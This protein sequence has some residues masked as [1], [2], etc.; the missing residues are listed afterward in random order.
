MNARTAPRPAGVTQIALAAGFGIGAVVTARHLDAHDE[1]PMTPFGFR[2]FSGPFESAGKDG[3]LILLAGMAAVSAVDA[4]AG[5]QLLRGRRSGFD[6]GFL[7]ALPSYALSIGFF[8]PIMLVGVPLR[9]VLSV[10]GRRALR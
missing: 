8:L 3:L 10:L 7:T 6:L 2:A 5:V 1:L 9:L 4:V